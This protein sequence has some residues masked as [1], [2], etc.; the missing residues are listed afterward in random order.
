MFHASDSDVF[1]AAKAV[2]DRHHNNGVT[3]VYGVPRGGAVPAALV[4]GF[5]VVP[6][7][8]APTTGTLVVDD[9]V[10]S[11][12]T[13]AR[14]DRS[15]FDA[16]FRKSWAPTDLA[17]SAVPVPNDDWIVFPWER[18]DEDSGPTEA[19]RRLLQFVGEDPTREGLLDTPGRVVKALGELTSGYAQDP[20]TIL[21]RTFDVPFDEMVVVTGITFTSLCEHHVLTF[22]GTVDVGYLPS[23]RVVGLSKIPRLVECFARRLQV[24]ERLTTEIAEAMNDQ[25]NPSGVGVVVRARHSC[26]GCRGVRQPSAE[27][28]T[29]KL[30]GQMRDD[31]RARSEF[32]ALTRHQ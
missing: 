20:A 9:L 11:G 12:T 22:S 21:E 10:D 24:Q 28:V 23:D 27:M 7:V 16:L 15:M 30:L 3:S 4:A 1:A 32:L 13:A 26:M 19:V 14:F 18:T 25:L 17:P 6:L 29:S 31:A 2:A 5:L 8:S